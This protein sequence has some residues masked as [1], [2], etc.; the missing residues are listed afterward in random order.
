[1][2][3]QRYL[4]AS[5]SEFINQ[6]SWVI[7]QSL[8][9]YSPGLAATINLIHIPRC[10]DKDQLIWQHTDSGALT[11]KDAFLFS[12][13][14]G[15]ALH[16]A[17][18]IWNPFIPPSKT[19]ILWRLIHNKLPTDEHLWDRGCTVV[20][21]CSLC[22][23]ASET[24]K[25]LFLYYNFATALWAWLSGITRCPVDRSSIFSVLSI[26]D[27]QW[28]THLQHTIIA[29]ITSVIWVIWHCRNGVRF[30][31]IFTPLHSAIHLIVA[32]VSLSGSLNS[33]HMFSSMEELRILHSL[34]IQGHRASAPSITPVLWHPPINHWIKCNTDGAAKGDPGPAGCEGI[35]RDHSAT[36]LGC[37]ASNLGVSYSL[38]AELVGA[39]FAIELPFDKGWHNLWLECDSMLVVSAF[40]NV[41]L[42]PWH[43]RNRWKNCIYLTRQIQ[44][45]VSHIFREDNTCADK[46]ASYSVSSHGFTWWDLVLGF[47]WENCYRNR[48]SFPN[49]RFR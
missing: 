22:G 11:F 29:A 20:S 19:F 26:L 39:M 17:K 49:Y 4:G 41:S 15:I 36:I 37:F 31:N 8:L 40:S 44:F 1:M 2:H 42:V 21:M 27:R 7:P 48:F 46:L 5:V 43:I 9:S 3:I 18:L 30:D 33:G 6:A 35:F 23:M 16:W 10:G 12:Q 47:L 14:R 32:T 25:H 24:S 45:R 28:S 34:C 38:H 13:P